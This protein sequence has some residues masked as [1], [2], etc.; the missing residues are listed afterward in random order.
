MVGFSR[1]SV[2]L[3]ALVDPRLSYYRTREPIGSVRNVAVLSAQ[4]A[5]ATGP[6]SSYSAETVARLTLTAPVLQLLPILSSRLAVSTFQIP[7]ALRLPPDILSHTV[8]SFGR[9]PEQSH[10]RCIV[11]SRFDLPNWSST[12]HDPE[13]KAKYRTRELALPRACGRR[14]WPLL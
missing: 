5:L 14:R 9:I 3:S 10:S 2:E 12:L 6:S 13:T 4:V 1:I 8:V 11:L 7:H